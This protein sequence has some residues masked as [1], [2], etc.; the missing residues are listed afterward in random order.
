MP[1][2]GTQNVQR[3][4]KWIVAGMIVIVKPLLTK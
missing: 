2:R 4:W 1:L 3:I